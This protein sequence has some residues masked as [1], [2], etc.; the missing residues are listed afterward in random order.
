[1]ARVSQTEP[2]PL[3]Q[4]VKYVSCRSERKQVVMRTIGF[5]MLLLLTSCL[6]RAKAA[7]DNQSNGA[8][9]AAAQASAR[10]D[11]SYRLIYS[12]EIEDGIADEPLDTNAVYIDVEEMPEFP[13]GFEAR[14]EYVRKTVRYPEACQKDSIQGR[15]IIFIVVDVI[16]GYINCSIAIDIIV[17]ASLAE[18]I[19]NKSEYISFEKF[20]ARVAAPYDRIEG[21][22]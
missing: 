10:D 9:V 6:N 16:F 5:F 4:D 12:P 17:V 22:E 21:S 20:L 18:K 7:S 11:V 13:G 19:D 15:V 8:S 14:S 1:M 3:S 2:S